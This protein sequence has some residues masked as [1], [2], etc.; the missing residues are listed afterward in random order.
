MVKGIN[1]SSERASECISVGNSDGVNECHGD[2][3][4]GGNDGNI[5]CHGGSFCGGNDCVSECHGGSVSGGNECSAW[6]LWQQQRVPRWQ[7]QQRQKP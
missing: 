4:S 2:S 6:K 7:H 3:T 1:E 5:V